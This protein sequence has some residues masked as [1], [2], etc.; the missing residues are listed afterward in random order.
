MTAPDSKGKLA[1]K[2]KST[3]GDEFCT[4]KK[5]NVSRSTLVVKEEKKNKDCC[6]QN[7]VMEDKRSNSR[8]KNKSCQSVRL[9][10]A[11]RSA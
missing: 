10:I 5:G 3:A 7:G 11:P 4:R 9:R 1:P 6:A 2:E 8:I